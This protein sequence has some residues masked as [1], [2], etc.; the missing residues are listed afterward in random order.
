MSHTLRNAPPL[1]NLAW[2]K[3]LHWDGRFH[4]L[5]E[6]ATQPI[7]AHDEMAENFFT[8]IFR[9]QSDSQYR[10]MNMQRQ[11]PRVVDEFVS[12]NV[13]QVAMGI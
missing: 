13:V 2:Q 7:W 3:D 12:K 4:S 6:E 5:Y 10:R 1:F 11:T 9:L 8:I